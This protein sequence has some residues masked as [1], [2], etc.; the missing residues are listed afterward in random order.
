MPISINPPSVVDM[1]L[2]PRRYEKFCFGVV[3]PAGHQV[4]DA[5]GAVSHELLR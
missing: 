3:Q 1:I 2:V 5:I 4:A